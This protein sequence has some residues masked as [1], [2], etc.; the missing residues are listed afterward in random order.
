MSSIRDVAKLANVSVSTVSSFINNNKTISEELR[1]RINKAVIDL[2]FQTNPVA[3]SLKN[4]KSGTIGVILPKI[5]SIFFP[6]LLN[7][8]EQTASK[9]GYSIMY[10]DSLQDLNKEKKYVNMLTQYWVEGIIL[11]SSADP[12]K[13]KDYIEFLVNK[14]VR[15]K[16]IPIVSLEGVLADDVISS[17]S[18]DNVYGGYLAT[19]HLIDIGCKS[20]AHITGYQVFKFSQG[21]T[22]GYKS[23]L[24]EYGLPCDEHL[25][26]NGDFSPLSGYNAMKEL[27]KEKRTFTGLFAA[28]DQ[29]AIGAM[30]A[31]KESGLRIPED[32]AV[33]GFDNVTFASLVEPSLTSINISKYQLGCLA[34][35]SLIKNIKNGDTAPIHQ[36][37]EI[38]LII[39]HSSE[40]KASCSWDL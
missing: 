27:L 39:R 35:E 11:D 32:I 1:I 7:G 22:V 2:D 15:N 34:M 9:N 29:E 18:I 6:Q 31:I 40:P 38:N 12:D 10:F 26:R 33:V 13:D 25:I 14:V 5:T 20:I 4:R 3:R 37:S 17:V 23:A 21:R 19:K 8:I 28:N 30:K 36:K 24:K 16:K